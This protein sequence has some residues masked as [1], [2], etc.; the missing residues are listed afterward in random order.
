LKSNEK[1]DCHWL[2]QDKDNN[3]L[4][5]FDSG[6]FIY[7]YINGKF[8]FTSKLPFKERKLNRFRIFGLNL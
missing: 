6:L 5:F 2:F 1:G 7:K 8:L 4:V 3:I